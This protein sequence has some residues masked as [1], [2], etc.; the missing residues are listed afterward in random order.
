MDGR[1][2]CRLE[3]LRLAGASKAQGDGQA[4]EW[5]RTTYEVGEKWQQ[6][7]SGSTRRMQTRGLAGSPIWWPIRRALQRRAESSGIG[8]DVKDGYQWPGLTMTRRCKQKVTH[9]LYPFCER[10]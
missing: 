4:V 9:F 5:N 7:L 1:N 8:V 2:G 6:S 10:G 3:A